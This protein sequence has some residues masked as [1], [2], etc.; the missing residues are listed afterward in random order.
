MPHEAEKLLQDYDYDNYY[1][2]SVIISIHHKNRDYTKI[3]EMFNRI[4]RKDDYIYSQT[5]QSLFYSQKYFAE[6][7]EYLIESI[8]A[9]VVLNKKPY[10]VASAKLCK[11]I[12]GSAGQ[13]IVGK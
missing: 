10:T 4:K 5:I 8:K 7:L 6:G 1:I 3:I 2:N 12:S 9:N 11:I 13:K